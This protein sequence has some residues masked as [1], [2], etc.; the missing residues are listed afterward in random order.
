MTSLYSVSLVF[1]GEIGSGR[2]S[3]LAIQHRN[4]LLF[5]HGQAGVACGSKRSRN[6]EPCSPGGKA[7]AA[8]LCTS[9]AESVEKCKKWLLSSIL[10]SIKT[11]RFLFFLHPRRHLGHSPVNGGIFVQVWQVLAAE[12]WERLGGVQR[13][14]PKRQFTHLFT[15]R[16]AA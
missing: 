7:R 3:S 9:Y 1:L 16:H 15:T 11:Y 12:D 13:P 8:I 10:K 14:R 4:P 2:G 6:T 5:R